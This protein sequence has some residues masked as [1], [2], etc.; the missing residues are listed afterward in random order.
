MDTKSY[1]NILN[2]K[3]NINEEDRNKLI[4]FL[5]VLSKIDSEFNQNKTLNELYI[6]FSENK[7]ELLDFS[8]IKNSNHKNFYQI[9]IDLYSQFGK[10]GNIIKNLIKLLL[11]IDNFNKEKIYYIFRNISIII[12]NKDINFEKL[13]NLISII[14]YLFTI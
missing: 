14:V 12:Q 4:E 7:K 3:E 6:Y 13:N 11:E 9:L 5:N 1:L 10:E 2:K 8:R